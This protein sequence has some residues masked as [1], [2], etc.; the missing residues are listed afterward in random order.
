VEYCLIEELAEDFNLPKDFIYVALTPKA[1][2]QL[3]K[4][5]VE[6][7]TF[8][9][10]YTSGEL[11]GN[12]DEFLVEQLRWFD[13]F[14]ALLKEIYPRAKSLNLNLGSIYFYWIK[15]MFDNIILTSRILNKF[16]KS[17]QPHKILFMGEKFSR[18]SISHVLQFQNVE[19]TYSRLIEHICKQNC[20]PFENINTNNKISDPSKYSFN[21]NLKNNIENIFPSIFALLRNVK[22]FISG[23]RML[24]IS[25]SKLKQSSHKAIFLTTTN[26]LCNA[27]KDFTEKPIQCLIY[28]ANAI[29]Y[30]KFPFIRKT[31]LHFEEYGKKVVK[32]INPHNRKL[33]ED[34]IYSWLNEKCG[35]DVSS[36]VKSRI[37]YFIDNICPKI[38]SMVDTFKDLYDSQEIDFVFTDQVYS[39][40]EHAAIVAARY[41]K[42]TRAV[43]IHH[44]ADAFEVKSRFFI[45][46]RLF[47]YYFTATK[48]EAEHEQDLRN[49]YKAQLPEIYSANYFKKTLNP[50]IEKNSDQKKYDSKQTIIFIPIMCAPW[51]QRPMEKGQPFPMEYVKWHKAL[52]HY[53]STRKDYNFIW[54]GYYLKNQKYDIMENTIDDKKYNNIEFH[55]SKLGHWL[56]KVDKVICDTPSTAFFESI[57]SLLPV[58]ALYRPND[59]ILR[60]NAYGAFGRSLAP[61]SDIEEGIS[62][63]ENFID[64]KPEDYLIDVDIDKVSLSDVLFKQNINK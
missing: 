21:I 60:K 16:I 5:N 2:Y 37:D 23:L 62:L 58:L 52:A 17:V 30:Y 64:A 11:R 47:D 32:N 38:I 41:S 44:G 15:Y 4:I 34:Q 55:S 54:K 33:T 13:E 43:Y 57:F 22:E 49:K 56:S 35:M 3:D 50:K 24:H 18:D 39:L 10:F 25:R 9:D 14:D 36:I 6:Y 19:S 48:G 51:P 8:E 53:F 63:I 7:I 42:N 20:I 27:I 1:V 31:P 40:E 46:V 45:L 29:K 28:N 12:T 61:Y 59:Q 26:L